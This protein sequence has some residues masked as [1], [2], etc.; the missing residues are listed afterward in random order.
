MNP[1]GPEGDQRY[2]QMNLTTMQGIAATAAVGNG[3]EPAPADNLPQSYTDNLLAT[4]LN[5]RAALRYSD[6]Q[7]RD[8][9]GKFGSG[10]GGGGSSGGGGHGGG[11]GGAKSQKSPKSKKAKAGEKPHADL[12]APKAKH[13]VA[14]PKSKGKLTHDQAKSA[15]SQMGYHLGGAATNFVPGKGF[16]THYAVTDA[17]GNSTSMSAGEMKDFV[18]ANKK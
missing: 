16:V 8:D 4:S 9:D 6:D 11:G 14:M 18:Y 5:G 7:P 1:I 3:G 13:D 10:G 12:H 15:M 2:M 17:N